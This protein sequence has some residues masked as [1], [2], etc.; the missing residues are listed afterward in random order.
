MPRWICKI[1]LNSKQSI[2]LKD[3]RLF[4]GSRHLV[5]VDGAKASTGRHQ[6][7]PLLPNNNQELELFL[8]V[9][10][11]ESVGVF[12]LCVC[13]SKGVPQAFGKKKRFDKS[14]GADVDPINGRVP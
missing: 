14:R 3:S 5:A 13:A 1:L 7:S 12:T 10:S 11:V 8:R 2:V 9:W 4:D 6:F